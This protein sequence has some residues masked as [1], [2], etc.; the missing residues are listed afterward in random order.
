[1]DVGIRQLRNNLRNYLNQVREGAE[2]VVTERGVAVARI[3]PIAGGRAIDRLISE[4]LITP[5]S[6]GERSLP[7]RRVRSNGSVSELVAEQ[8]R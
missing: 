6:N 8:R 3:V 1:M 4:G 2:V 7:S 5:A